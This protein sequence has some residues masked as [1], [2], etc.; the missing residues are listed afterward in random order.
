MWILFQ[1]VYVS[2]TKGSF[3]ISAT[4]TQFTCET[5]KPT[6]A[7]ETHVIHDLILQENLSELIEILEVTHLS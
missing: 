3:N 1:W 6:K 7:C 4:V 2:A 5:Y